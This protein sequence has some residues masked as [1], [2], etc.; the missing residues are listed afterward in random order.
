[1]KFHHT[2][3]FNKDSPILRLITGKGKLRLPIPVADCNTLGLRVSLCP[4]GT[5]FE[6]NASRLGGGFTS[7]DHGSFSPDIHLERDVPDLQRLD[8]RAPF[9]HASEKHR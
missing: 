6:V 8:V 5:G 3:L 4:E 9:P 2:L 7:S 1:M